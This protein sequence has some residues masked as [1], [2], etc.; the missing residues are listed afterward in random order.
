MPK[1]L[2]LLL[3]LLSLIWGASF[4]FIK[5][6]L[7]YSAPSLIAFWRC[8]FGV[9]AIVC[10][11]MLLRKRWQWERATLLM[12]IVVGVI[13]T[14]LPW[15]LI[16][17]SEQ[18]L[19]SNL[20]SVMNATTPLW[21][22]LIGVIF[23]ATRPGWRQWCGIA[24][25][26]IGLLVL[27]EINPVTLAGVNFTGFLGMMTATF[28]YGISGHLVRRYLSS[29]NVYQLASGTLLVGMLASGAVALLTGKFS[30]EPVS[31]PVPIFA[32]LGLGVMGS[33]V[34]N[35]LNFTLIQKGSAEFASYTTYLIP[36]SAIFWGSVFLHEAVSWTLVTGMVLILSGVFLASRKPTVC[37]GTAKQSVAAK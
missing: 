2:Y 30:F 16:A 12:L 4:F 27:L 35:L 13:N 19:S 6:L 37:S 25:G 28:C 3:I 24:I 11:S 33:G 32:L 10:I 8:A 15:S 5:I 36:V 34:A 9:I 18:K 29:L 22:L 31:H 7:G 14:A 20:A 23:F 1:Y 17:F 26:F 21:T